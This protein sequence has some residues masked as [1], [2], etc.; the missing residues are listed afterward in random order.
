MTRTI[1]M[2]PTVIVVA[3][4]IT[5]VGLGFW[6]LG[7][8]EWKTDLIARHE[9]SL[10]MSSDVRFPRDE[11]E[12]EGTLYRH[13]NVRCDRVIEMRSTAGR[14]VA[15]RQGLSQVAR[16][17]LDGGGE[18]EIVLGWSDRPVLVDW[19]G[20]DATG[21]IAPSGDYARL[22][23]SPPLAGLEPN[24]A[25]DPTDLPNNHLAYAGQWFF[26]A[27]TALVIYWLALR[28]KWR[29]ED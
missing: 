7:R 26:F 19:S 1:P 20:G 24:T 27:I 29:G 10:A 22:V 21:F 16:C 4:A 5:M 8:A 17:L 9:Q 12:V 2:L 14:S 23:A 3:A 18:A 11:S 13:S 25:P 6:Q 15:G 28:R